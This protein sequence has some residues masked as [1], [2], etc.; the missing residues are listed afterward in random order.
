MNKIKVKNIVSIIFILCIV[1]S[2]ASPAY[3]K[4][5]KPPKNPP[6]DGDGF[7]EI[8]VTLTI[9]G[10]QGSSGGIQPN[11]VVGGPGGQYAILSSII[12]TQTSPTRK[13]RGGVSI[14]IYNSIEGHALAWAELYKDGS[15]ITGTDTCGANSLNLY[16]CS[17]YTSWV[18]DTG[19]NWRNRGSTTVWWT[20]GGSTYSY[21][22]VNKT[23]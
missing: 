11:S 8:V 15:F 16:F 23:F 7:E 4:G 9:E 19:T 22:D 6:P 17:I 14:Q 12:K 5:D 2:T 21:V 13:V 18:N 3:A 1:L 10:P 20:G